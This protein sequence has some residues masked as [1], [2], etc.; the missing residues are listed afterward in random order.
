MD[1]TI[2]CCYFYDYYDFIYCYTYRFIYNHLFKLMVGCRVANKFTG[3]YFM[4]SEAIQRLWLS[5]LKMLRI[6]RVSG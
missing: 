3:I 6:I 5:C 4:G 1:F 2:Y